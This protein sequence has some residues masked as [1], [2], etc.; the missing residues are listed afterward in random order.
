MNKTLLPGERCGSVRI[1]SSKSAAHRVLICA[2]LGDRPVAVYLNG[3]SQ[4]IQATASCLRALGAEIEQNGRELRIRPLDRSPCPEEVLLPAGE[5]GS[6]L[7]FLLPLSGALGRTAFFA[8]SSRT[9]PFIISPPTTRN[10]SMIS[11]FFLLPA[12]A[13]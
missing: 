4:D 10:P 2:A 8:P 6:T 12:Y 13:G 7:R 11:T 1:P 5:S 3:L 9:C